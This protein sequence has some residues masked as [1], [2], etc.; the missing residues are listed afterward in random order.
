M[1]GVDIIFEAK[2][3]N[4]TFESNSGFAGA[5]PARL[6][7]KKTKVVKAVQDF[8]LEVSKGETIGIVGE[9]GCG[10]STLAR[11]MAGIIPATSGAM[12]YDGDDFNKFLADSKKA[13]KVQMVF[14]DPLSSINPRHK[15]LNIIGE[16]PVAHGIIKRAQMRDYVVAQMGTVG[17]SP[18]FINRYPHQFSGGQRQ[19]ISIA[20]AL[21]VK[22]EFLICDEAVAALDVSVQ[23]Q[24]INL[25]MDIKRKFD[26]TVI[27]ISHD[28]SVIRHFCYRVLVMYLGRTV[29]I[30]E[31]SELFNNPLHPYTRTLIA[32][33]PRISLDRRDFLPITGEIPS[34][35][36]PPSGCAFHTRCPEQTAE[37]RRRCPPLFKI[38]ESRS[39]ACLKVDG[40]N[41]S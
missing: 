32:G 6:F 10:K 18:D 1:K 34:P 28:L 27:F 22:P 12:H 19:R 9:S 13:L 15:V 30:A 29:E 20:R 11:M 2:N 16:A 31:T 24:I 35:L 37:C 36:N 3:V 39:H 7:G 5:L 8:S 21:A 41:C 33:M 17:L 40:G 23:A 38:S 26:L 4:K 14:Q 25:L